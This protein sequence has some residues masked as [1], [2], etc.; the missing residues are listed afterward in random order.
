M[1]KKILSVLILAAV[2]G[3]QSQA[4]DD[5]NIPE[6]RKQ[7]NETFGVLPEKMPGAEKDSAELVQL[8]KKLFFEKRLSQNNSISC[9]SC[10]A[11]EGKH[12]GVDN[13]PTSPGAFG[14]RGGR[15]SPTVLN[16]GFQPMQFWDGRAEDL[17]H[18]AK[19][20]ILNPVEMAM[21]ADTDVIARLRS[22]SEYKE[23][24]GKAF[25]GGE[26]NYDHVAEAIAA[27]ERTLITRDRFDDFQKGDDDALSK[28]ELRGLALFMQTGCTTCHF[29]PTIGGTQFQKVGLVN[30]Y[31]TQ[32]MG[33]YEVSKET[34]DKFKFKVPMLRNVALTGPY[35]H[36]GKQTTLEGT[37]KTMGWLQLGKELSEAEVSD[38]SS[39]LRALTDKPREE[40]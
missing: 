17:E 35:F 24:F 15:N 1:T 39:F 23:L 21:P 8:G 19:G 2:S 30:H 4:A 26:I 33:R 40:K 29:G 22:I 31:Q 16:A 25:E 38:I 34:D 14:K 12:G 6:L 27:F 20:P 7:A 13:E 28:K 11:I 37:V 3:F 5:L 32:D 10:H 18:Q 36:D 9:N